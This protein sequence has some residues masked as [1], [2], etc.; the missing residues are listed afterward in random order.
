MDITPHASVDEFFHEV[1]MEALERTSVEAT[2]GTECY[3]VCLLGEFAKARITD[4]P[5][6]LKLARAPVDPAER[7]KALK[8]V[9]DTTLYVTGFFAA[10]L[11]RHLVDADYYM[12]LG[13]AAY[14]EL[15][16]R[17]SGASSIASIYSELA[18]KFPRFVDVLNEVRKQVNFASDDI[19][20]LYQQWVETRS[21]WIEHR[22][23]MMGVLVSADS[24]GYVQ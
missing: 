14:R 4:E 3:L 16:R 6:S 15:A 20:K 11:D 1:V 9:G 17:F 22:L 23:R 24:K 10:S 18:A 8:E 19:I 13:E 12:S 2:E 21:D 5:L 7:V